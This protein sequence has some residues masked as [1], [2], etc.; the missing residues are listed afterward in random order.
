MELI[1]KLFLI[2]ALLSFISSDLFIKSPKEL[3]EKFNGNSIKCS[4]SNFGRIPYG[5]NLIGRLHYDPVNIDT[6][7][8]CKEIRTITIDEGHS[9]DESP[10]VMVDRYDKLT[11]EVIAHLSQKLEMFKT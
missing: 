2:I 6:D 7:M 3:K 1:K 11:L 5:Y 9:V 4:L 10:I 8:A